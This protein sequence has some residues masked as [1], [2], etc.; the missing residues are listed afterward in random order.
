MTNRYP[1]TN[2]HR[3]LTHLSKIFKVKCEEDE[4]SLEAVMS[5]ID[6]AE[7]V[8]IPFRFSDVKVI[9][10]SFPVFHEFMCP[11][12]NSLLWAALDETDAPILL[13]DSMMQGKDSLFICQRAGS[14]VIS[15]EA[16]F[17]ISKQ[18][19]NKLL[20]NTFAGQVAYMYPITSFTE[21]A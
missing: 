16:G 10:E 12:S 17:I 6:S 1:K 7:G 4:D 13:T 21:I 18:K 8:D 3:L 9:Y 19:N 5:S 20:V 15:S 11:R 14:G 2:N